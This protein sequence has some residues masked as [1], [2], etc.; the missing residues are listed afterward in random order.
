MLGFGVG[1]LGPPWDTKAPKALAPR[2]SEKRGGS[3]EAEVRQ[4]RIRMSQ[5]QKPATKDHEEPKPYT[6]LRK[7]WRR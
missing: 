6:I 2:G 5:N 3:A 1:A 7:T 4:E